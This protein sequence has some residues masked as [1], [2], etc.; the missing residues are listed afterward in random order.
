MTKP[1]EANC[2]NCG[3]ERNAFVRASHSTGGD[4]D[5]VVWSTTMEI[6]ECCGCNDLSIRR[7]AWSDSDDA[8][9]TYW[10][11]KQSRKPEWHADLTDDN[12]RQA[13]QEV[14]LASN[15]GLV[16]L[17]SIGV[18]TLLDRSFFL[19]LKKDRGSFA[20]KLK[21]MVKEGFLLENEKKIFQ[22]IVDV[23]SAA[24]HRA[25][26]PTQETLTKILTAAESFLYQK[27]ILPGD[28]KA[29]EKDTPS[30]KS[31]A[32]PADLADLAEAVPETD[33]IP[34]S[35]GDEVDLGGATPTTTAS[36]KSVK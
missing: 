13:M 20:N 33:K 17:A 26:L 14:Y 24:A 15:Q 35:P 32:G 3:G 28:A 8:E 31:Q 9:I 22:S 25:H 1:V 36:S 16:V 34:T 12:L 29:M 5:Y 18:R 27:F 30:R 19:L 4:N 10:P 7:M 2:N 23:G 11:P 6:L 21:V